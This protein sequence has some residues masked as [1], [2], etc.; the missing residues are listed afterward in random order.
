V[1]DVI[2]AI[3]GGGRGV[4]LS[5]LT[6]YRSK[7]AVPF[8]GKFR[9]IDIAI[10]NSLHAGL[11]R[12]YVLTQFHSASLHHH[13]A[14]T[15]RFDVFRGGFVHL[16][17][18]EQGLGNRDWYQGTADAVRQNLPWIADE[19]AED[20][21]ILSG[22]QLY[23]M[24]LDRFLALH[25]ESGA[26]FT[27]A[28]KPVPQS[29]APALGVLRVDG[30]G[31]V[32]EFV[33]KPQTRAEIERLALDAGSAARLGYSSASGMVLASM[34]IYVF[35]AEVL[36]RLLLGTTATDFG[37]EVIP[38]A[39]ESSRIQAFAHAGYWRDIG[40]I[41]SFHEANMDLTRPLPPLNLYDQDNPIY[42]NGRFLPGTKINRCEVEQ[43]IL[44][45]G[46]ILSESRIQHSI[47]G[48]RAVV[49]QGTHIEQSVIM[50]ARVF[51]MNRHGHA[52]P[53]GI[54]RDCVVR[55]AIVDL[56]A[57]IGDGAQLVNEKG[58]R[59][60]EAETHCIHD[61]I[62][63]VARGAVIPPGTVI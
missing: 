62:I 30:E 27:I 31:R 37:K 17:S 9:L 19:D 32:V 55:R 42:T 36:R 20:V 61:G 6:R 35:R 12:I 63:V 39:I 46:S 58:V 5:P 45:E 24:R 38:R 2:T 56:D 3:L 11:D 48:I 33:E 7:P 4:R 40:T 41:P 25:R 28:V 57:R 53:L 52:V 8:G 14:S 23:L 18:A 50:G 22:D 10:S 1:K 59:E 49:R 21:M 44:C 43:S 34:G 29:E 51:D 16:L 60:L 13:I 54:G 47:I 26:D 15:Y